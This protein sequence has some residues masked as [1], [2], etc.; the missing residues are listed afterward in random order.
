MPKE[1]KCVP[2]KFGNRTLHYNNTQTELKLDSERDYII[3]PTKSMYYIQNIPYFISDKGKE[4]YNNDYG[5][6]KS[7]IKSIQVIGD[8]EEIKERILIAKNWTFGLDEDPSK[9][10]HFQTNTRNG[11]YIVRKIHR[12]SD[13]STAL[14]EHLTNKLI[15]IM[16]EE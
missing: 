2:I 1:K 16:Q 12:E 3:N 9:S 13:L 14:T 5:S 8:F 7:Y 10:A 6:P 11:Y 15:E 4:N